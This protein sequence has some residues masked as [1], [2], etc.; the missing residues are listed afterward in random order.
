MGSTHDY[1]RAFP[2]AA[3]SVA[4]MPMI[5]RASSLMPVRTITVEAWTRSTANR[6]PLPTDLTEESL[7]LA[8]LQIRKL[9]EE[10]QKRV[11]LKPTKLIIRPTDL[12]RLRAR[13]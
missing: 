6:L 12:A 5:V 9:T 11:Q 3:L 8:L 7:R 4:A 1:R 13:T 10:S 2:R